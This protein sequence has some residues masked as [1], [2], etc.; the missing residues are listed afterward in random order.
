MR[1]RFSL[2][3]IAAGIA[4]NVSADNIYSD[5]LL[6]PVN[7]SEEINGWSVMLKAGLRE[8][9]GEITNDGYR[10]ELP[11]VTYQKNF[12]DEIFF[13]ASVPW[14]NLQSDDTKRYTLGDPSFFTSLKTSKNSSFT[15]GVTEPAANRPIE[16]DVV[17]FM[18]FYTVAYPLENLTLRG[19]LATE[20][21]DRY[22]QEGQDDILSFGFGIDGSQWSANIIRK[23]VVDGKWWD[24]TKPLDNTLNRTNLT[25]KWDSSINTRWFNT[26]S[27]MGGLQ[28]NNSSQ[29]WLGLQL[30]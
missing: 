14:V 2:F 22:A 13:R 9:T 26:L 23:Q 27:V 15:V 16:P 24:I 7:F 10:M 21:P 30:L 11:R 6:Q 4:A 17:R 29:W 20:I 8:G 19:Q 5:N 12:H 3:L 28:Y 25:V 1:F 18:A